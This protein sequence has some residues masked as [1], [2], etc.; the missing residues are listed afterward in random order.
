MK[1]KEINAGYEII[2][3][4]PV[5]EQGFAIGHSETAPAPYVTWQY[6]TADPTH[7]RQIRPAGAGSGTGGN[8]RKEKEEEAA[9]RDERGT[10]GNPAQ[11][12]QGA[13]RKESS[14]K[15]SR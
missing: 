4:F 8:A 6:R 10:A 9:P 13:V 1:E 12:G 14:R 3:R 5:G 11:A 7:Y 2:E 15:E